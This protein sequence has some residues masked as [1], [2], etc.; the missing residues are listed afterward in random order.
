MIIL[1]QIFVAQEALIF[2]L[3]SEWVYFVLQHHL[4]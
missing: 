4:V 2:E 3:E 1:P